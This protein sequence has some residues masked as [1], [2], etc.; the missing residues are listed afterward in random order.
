LAIEDEPEVRCNLTINPA[1]RE[2]SSITRRKQAELAKQEKLDLILC[3]VMLPELDGDGVIAALRADAEAVTIPLTF[4]P[5]WTGRQTFACQR[6]KKNGY[7]YH[8]VAQTRF[9]RMV[10]LSYHLR[11][12]DIP[13]FNKVAYPPYF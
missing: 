2:V 13:L 6:D 10:D 7:I 5:R 8:S 9:H 11:H 12:S 1:A 4:S 3:D